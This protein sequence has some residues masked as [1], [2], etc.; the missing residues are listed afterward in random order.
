MNNEQFIKVL[1]TEAEMVVKH[2]RT[3]IQEVNDIKGVS[4]S[5][6]ELD[7]LPRRGWG[8]GPCEVVLNVPL[9]LGLS[10]IGGYWATVVV[11]VSATILAC[12]DCRYPDYCDD[13][14]DGDG[15][16]TVYEWPNPV[17]A[18]AGM[19]DVVAECGQ[20]AVRTYLSPLW[21]QR[22]ALFVDGDWGQGITRAIGE[23]ASTDE[24][25][26]VLRTVAE[27]ANA[28]LRQCA[29]EQLLAVAPLLAEIDLEYT[30]EYNDEGGYFKSLNDVTVTLVSGETVYFNG[31]DELD[32][33]CESQLE[34]FVNEIDDELD[35]VF[36]WEV[37][38]HK[39]AFYLWMETQ[40]GVADF[41]TFWQALW[42]WIE[43]NGDL[44]SAAFRDVEKS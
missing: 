23:M 18:V 1:K 2:E 28:Q 40:Y 44:S 4:V 42:A 10:D 13:E 31:S 19:R 15:Y 38:G 39:E 27:T 7:Q 3:A 9:D 36:D 14:A 35:V 21:A 22:L 43:S 34:Q 20:A 33:G 30:N 5:C 26:A 41:M 24:R 12:F 6:Y 37:A 17:C 8:I 29:K 32:Y 16:L 11:K 25:I